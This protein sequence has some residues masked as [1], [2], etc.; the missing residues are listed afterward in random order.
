MKVMGMVVMEVVVE[1][2][3]EVVVEEV[4]EVVV[5]MIT[6]ML[7]P[8]FIIDVCSLAQDGSRSSSRARCRGSR[9]A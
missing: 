9:S 7:L 4:V 2:V 3:V 8:V 5:A 1:E 6:T